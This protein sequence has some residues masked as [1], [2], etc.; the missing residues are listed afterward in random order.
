M[1]ILYSYDSIIKLI[2]VKGAKVSYLDDYLM[3]NHSHELF[4]KRE[5]IFIYSLKMSNGEL[6]LF[7]LIV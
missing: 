2:I 1:V 3:Y 5:I 7:I 6:L 4:G